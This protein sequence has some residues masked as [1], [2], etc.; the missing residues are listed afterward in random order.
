[1]GTT[2]FDVEEAG[3]VEGSSGGVRGALQWLLCLLDPGGAPGFDSGKG[4]AN[5]VGEVA[6]LDQW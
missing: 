5:V 3:E 1:M 4:V 2:A 6:E